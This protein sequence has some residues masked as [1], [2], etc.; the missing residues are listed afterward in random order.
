MMVFSAE[1]ALLY[2]RDWR[3]HTF[4]HEI[5]WY[6]GRHSGV[7]VVP[8]TISMGPQGQKLVS[9]SAIALRDLYRYSADSL[10][11]CCGVRDYIKKIKDLY[12][13]FSGTRVGFFPIPQAEFFTFTWDQNVSYSGINSFTMTPLKVE[14]GLAILSS[15]YGESRIAYSEFDAFSLSI[16]GGGTF[17]R[18]TKFEMD[19]LQYANQL[20]QMQDGLM[21][22]RNRHVGVQAHLDFMNG[23]MWDFTGKFNYRKVGGHGGQSYDY[24]VKFEDGTT[25]RFSHLSRY[26]MASLSASKRALLAR[27]P[28]RVGGTLEANLPNND[29]YRGSVTGNRSLVDRNNQIVK[30]GMWVRF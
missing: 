22:E 8:Y 3:G 14:I 15:D 26:W 1:G 7:H 12:P 2:D 21:L 29:V 25:E 6:E 13:A 20:G 28:Y 11:R 17:L 4:K 10:N 16:I 5:R 9:F 30:L 19:G 27:K 24:G 23:W 18:F